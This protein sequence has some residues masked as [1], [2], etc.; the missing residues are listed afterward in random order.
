MR[1]QLLAL[2]FSNSN[3]VALLSWY[4]TTSCA[5]PW[6]SMKFLLHI[7]ILLISSTATSSTSVL[8]FVF[9]FCLALLKIILLCPKKIS[10]LPI[11]FTTFFWTIFHTETH[12]RTPIKSMILSRSAQD[13]N[14][15]FL[16][17]WHGNLISK[18]N[19]LVSKVI[20]LSVWKYLKL[21]LLTY[22]VRILKWRHINIWTILNESNC[23]TIF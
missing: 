5:Y 9:K 12:T 10:H 20:L 15:K 6:H 22:I 4:N 21:G 16:T 19:Y 1:L 2:P 8:F 17:F 11:F 3:F 18:G 13:L 14:L 7:S 23:S